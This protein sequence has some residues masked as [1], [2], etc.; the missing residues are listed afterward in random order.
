M[1]RHGQMPLLMILIE[2]E[3][4]FMLDLNIFI[5]LSYVLHMLQDQVWHVYLQNISCT[6]ISWPSSVSRWSGL[7][8][9][10]RRWL[11]STYEG[12]V[13]LGSYAKLGWHRRAGLFASNCRPCAQWQGQVLGRV[14]WLLLLS[15]TK[16]NL[17]GHHINGWRSSRTLPLL[18]RLVW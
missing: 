6:G 5:S 14:S 7:Q 10:D 17:W 4:K 1:E 11:K 18:S 12:E 16:C 15:S 8:S 2:G 13:I 9:M 3:H